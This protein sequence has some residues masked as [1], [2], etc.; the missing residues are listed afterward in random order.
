[1]NN[2]TMS[3]SKYLM[4]MT[5]SHPNTG[6]MRNSNL[7]PQM[8]DG[9][10]HLDIGSLFNSPKYANKKEKNKAQIFKSIDFADQS[11]LISKPEF[12]IKSFS[13]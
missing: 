5:A 10:T 13:R 2:N 4:D 11:S 6:K 8:E 7:T 12:L 1:M 9:G 3:D